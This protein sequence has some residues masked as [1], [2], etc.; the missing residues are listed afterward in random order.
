MMSWRCQAAVVV[1]TGLVCC[2]D[3]PS[4]EDAQL[5]KQNLAEVLD[6]SPLPATPPNPTN[7][8]ADNPEA[9]RLGAVS[10]LSVLSRG[11]AIAYR[12]EGRKKKPVLDASRISIGQKIEIQVKRGRLDCTVDS[13]TMGLESVWP[14]SSEADDGSEPEGKKYDGT[15]EQ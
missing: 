1:L 4:P 11:Y 9:A 13:T 7:A 12:F 8:Y 6:L 10:P 5:T 15:S 2:C 3:S 14:E